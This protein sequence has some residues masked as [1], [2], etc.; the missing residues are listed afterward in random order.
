MVLDN[1]WLLPL[2]P[3]LTKLDKIWVLALALVLIAFPADGLLV[4]S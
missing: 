4:F 2:A 1:I 3:L